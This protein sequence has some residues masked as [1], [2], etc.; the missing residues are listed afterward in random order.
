MKLTFSLLFIYLS[1]F[2]TTIVADP[3]K[4]Q[5]LL[6]GPGIYGL[7]AA[8]LGINGFR[9]SISD[10][11]GDFSGRNEF[12]VSLACDG[13]TA[14]AGIDTARDDGAIDR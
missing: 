10:S 1:F 3:Q 4:P 11:S 7:A 2:P 6:V 13:E 8:K 9:E 5:V 12:C 14:F